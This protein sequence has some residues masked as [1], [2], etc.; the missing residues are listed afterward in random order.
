MSTH[1]APD[2]KDMRELMADTASAWLRLST[3]TQ[4]LL[5]TEIGQLPENPDWLTN[6]H[7]A[8]AENRDVGN[9]W[10]LKAPA[11]KA[12]IISAFIQ[13]SS[14]FEAFVQ[15]ADITNDQ[16]A[17]DTMVSM[18]QTLVDQIDGILTSIHPSAHVMASIADDFASVHTAMTQA[19]DAAK[20]ANVENQKA[21]IKSAAAIAQLKQ[22]IDDLSGD[23]KSDAIS[24]GET[25]IENQIELIFES[26]AES[27]AIPILGT[28]LVIFSLIIDIVETIEASVE[29]TEAIDELNEAMKEEALEVQT[30]IALQGVLVAFDRLNTLYIEAQ[31]PGPKLALIWKEERDK[32]SLTIDAL[33]S[34]AQPTEMMALHQLADAKSVWVKLS[35]FAQTLQTLEAS[36]TAK[37]TLKVSAKAKG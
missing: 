10:H 35:R 34:G 8:L 18:L 24:G 7:R 22:K 13:Y 36:Q 2:L 17:I 33:K 23:L 9:R 20:V 4:A 31:Q 14:S 25:I 1:L 21:L 5:K 11:I 19:A 32:L 3:F 30:A 16:S 37:A 12:P 15:L 28:G 26:V 6:A 27:G 29:I